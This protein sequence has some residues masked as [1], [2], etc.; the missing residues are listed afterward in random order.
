MLILIS[1]YFRLSLLFH[2]S[3]FIHG[4]LLYFFCL[5]RIIVCFLLLLLI[6]LRLCWLIEQDN[7]W[8]FDLDLVCRLNDWKLSCC[9]TI[10]WGGFL[11]F[12]ILSDWIS[13]SVWFTTV[14]SSITS[15]YYLLSSWL[16]L[17]GSTFSSSYCF[18]L[19]ISGVYTAVWFYSG[20]FSFYY[21]FSL[22]KGF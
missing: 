7:V 11:Y 22:P 1:H 6:K 9:G 5:M 2:N 20:L 8:A 15:Y 17:T 10:V 14:F 4:V 21:I 19:T 18:W 16:S 3:L 13:T 12:P